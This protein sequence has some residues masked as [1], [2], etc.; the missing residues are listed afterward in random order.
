MSYPLGDQGPSHTTRIYLLIAE[1]GLIERQDE[2][3]EP[4][5]EEGDYEMPDDMW[6]YDPTKEYGEDLINE[7]DLLGSPAA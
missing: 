1:N 2:T 3:D 6:H 5:I 4:L 7:E